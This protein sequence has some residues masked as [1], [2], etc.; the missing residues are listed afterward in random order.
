MALPILQLCDILCHIPYMLPLTSA[1]KNVFIN[2]R[3]AFQKTSF[4]NDVFLTLHSTRK[5]QSFLHVHQLLSGTAVVQSLGMTGGMPTPPRPV[6]VTGRDT[7]ATT[8]SGDNHD[9]AKPGH[10][11]QQ[12]ERRVPSVRR[13]ALTAS[14]CWRL[15][16][17]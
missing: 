9:T 17:V 1:L 11:R 8:L 16:D 7:I 14:V 10:Q 3:K 6:C 13:V 12:H 5:V 15:G 4:C 2:P